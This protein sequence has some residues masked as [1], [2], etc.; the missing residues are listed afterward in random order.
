LKLILAD[1][2][3]VLVCIANSHETGKSTLLKLYGNPDNYA[4]K[5]GED[6]FTNKL[7]IH[8]NWLH[9][10]GYGYLHYLSIDYNTR[11]VHFSNDMDKRL[12]YGSFIH[13]VDTQARI[14]AAAPET[15]EVSA[16]EITF[17]NHLYFIGS[18]DS[19]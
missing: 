7:P 18:A 10:R 14:Y 15:N 2:S 17:N 3:K 11:Y 19:F 6:A 1:Y 12:E 4:Y 16:T 8:L 13:D 5:F 9:F